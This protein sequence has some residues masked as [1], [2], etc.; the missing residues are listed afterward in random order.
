[1]ENFS[2]KQLQIFGILACII[3]T[4]CKSELESNLTNLNKN[5]F[6]KIQKWNS[7]NYLNDT[8][9]IKFFSTM[10]YEQFRINK[11]KRITSLKPGPSSDIVEYEVWEI[12][13]DSILILK[14][15]SEFK[16]VSLKNQTLSFVSNENRDDSL[17]LTKFNYQSN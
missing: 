9:L 15:R 3:L 1:M 10:E 17:V 14:K 7:E 8:L 6:W 5:E 13:N 11:K 16:I 4:S 2:I 12:K